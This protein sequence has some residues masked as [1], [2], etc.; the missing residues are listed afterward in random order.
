[1]E[2]PDG[3]HAE[4]VDLGILRIY[5]SD[6]D[7][8]LRVCVL[9]ALFGVFCP[10]SLPN[11]DDARFWSDDQDESRKSAAPRDDEAF[12]DLFHPS[13]PVSLRRPRYAESVTREGC[14]IGNGDVPRE[15]RGEGVAPRERTVPISVDSIVPEASG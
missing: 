1:M 9:F 11:T 15:D 12:D 14:V 5:T 3:P 8:F 2:G 6:R 7:G 10:A 4:G 13:D